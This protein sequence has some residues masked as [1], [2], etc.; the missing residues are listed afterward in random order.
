MPTRREWL[1]GPIKPTEILYQIEGPTIFTTF[2][3]LTN[4]IFFKAD[5]ARELDIFLAC[6][7]AN[8]EL[9]LLKAGRISVR[10]VLSYR[11]TWLIQT[12]ARLEVEEFEEVS[13]N[14]IRELLPPS[15]VPLYAKHDTAPDSVPEA[16]A[17]MSF[18]F[19]G[20]GMS[21]EA[22]LLSTFKNLVDQISLLIR[23]ALLPRA[24]VD[25]R[26]N[27][28]FD[29]QIAPPVLASCLIAIKTPEIDAVGLRGYKPTEFLSPDRLREEAFQRGRSLWDAIEATTS[30][31][32][33]GELSEADIQAHR[34]VLGQI[35]N[36]LP[37]EDNELEM[38]QVTYRTDT[39]P[40]TVSIDKAIGDRL[41]LAGSPSAMTQTIEGAI[42]EVNGEA[43]TF[44][45]KNLRDR[46]ITCALLNRI[47]DAMSSASQLGLGQR[48]RITGRFWKRKRRD[49]IYVEQY[50]QLLPPL[51][52]E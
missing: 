50:P 29:V 3:G 39:G 13:F 42:M 48:L 37:T 17:L 38:L 5:E 45:I 46:Q 26:N 24:L 16:T 25:G 1:S 23:K 40:K 9:E 4:Y 28:F 2:I 47:F 19:V 8:E 31:A 10:G 22:I 35:V 34:E 15:G 20:Q 49:Y 43:R 52:D 36:L 27:R 32:A 30:A 12:N 21:P 44:I 14:N 11:S 51:R 6:P 18:K 33:R 7:I 41:V